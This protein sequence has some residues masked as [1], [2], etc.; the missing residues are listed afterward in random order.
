VTITNTVSDTNTTYSAGTG[1]DLSTTTFSVD[2]SDFMTNGVDNRVLTATSADA[3]NAEAN[4]T[5]DGNNLS[6]ISASEAEPVLTLKA[7]HTTVNRSGELQFL[8][9]AADTED[10]E[11]LGLITFYGEDEGN[12]NTKF[13]H[14]QGKI[15]ESAE[16]NEGGKLEFAVASH[17]AGMAAGLTIVDGDA[18][19]EVDVTIANGTSSVTA[20]QGNMTVQTITSGTWQGTA[21]ATDQQKH[22]AYFEFK[23]YGTG[24][25]TNYEMMDFLSD[26]NS[27]YEHN[28]S[29]GS[30]G[31]TA[32]THQTIMRTGGTVMPHAGT[33]KGWTGWAASAGSGTV[34][35]GL[36]KFTPTRNSSSSISAVLLINTQ[37]TALGNAKGEDFAEEEFEVAFAAG[38][39]I[40]SAVKNTSGKICYFSSTL[41]VEWN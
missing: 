27:P 29:T 23:G 17:D 2:V 1:L 3:M 16:N 13:A 36:F 41:E 22:L 33:L 39:M 31:L 10:N 4:L 26:T 35:I 6:I 40:V 19:D 20:I 14:I 28:T 21:I 7:T 30:D 12:N 18:D 38:D 37:F 24:D 11:R 32:Q 25:G 15:A 5:F 9:D 8:K 34:D